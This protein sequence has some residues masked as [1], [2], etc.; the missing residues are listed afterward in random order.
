MS[1]VPLIWTSKGNLPIADLE[2]ET[3]WEDAADYVK[4]TEMYFLKGELVKASTHVYCRKPLE[5]LPQQELIG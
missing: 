1:E 5:A 3:S 2:V 4:F